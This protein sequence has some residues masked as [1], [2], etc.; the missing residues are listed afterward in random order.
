MLGRGGIALLAALAL[1][2]CVGGVVP[3]TSSGSGPVA[4]PSP[5][6]RPAG[7][8][9]QPVPSTPLAPIPSTAVPDA[10]TAVTAGLA[11]GPSVSSLPITNEG[12]ERALAAFRISCPSLVRRTDP[13]GLTRGADWKPACDA[14]ARG[15]DARAFFA[16]W[17]EAVQVGDGKAFATGYYI[18]E[19]A[20]SRSHRPGYAPIYARP[21]DLVDVDLGQFSADLK[22][23]KIRGRVEGTNFVPYY[24]RTMIEEGAL[25]GKARILGYAVDPVELFFLQVQ[26]SGLVRMSDGDVL[27]IGYDSQ[28]G[29]DY[30][31]IGKLML[32]RGLIGRGEASMQ[33]IVAWLHANPEQGRAIMRENKSYVFFRVLDGPP[34]GAMGLPVSD[35]ATVAADVRFVPLGAPVFL[36]MDRTD[37]TGLW[38]AQDTGGAIKGTNRFDTFWGAGDEAR[39]IAGGMS[40][41]GTAFLLVPTGTL[42]RLGV[43]RP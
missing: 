5:P 27:R 40:A 12:A 32:D 7:P 38:V 3:P 19:I 11:A 26:G 21:S 28:N 34:L 41:R 17:F 33:G 2:A 15:G 29:R 10:V 25:T 22:G 24:D 8:V 1:S 43:A 13:T 14:A 31:G 39:A 23:K 30:T 6:T 42:A 20:G 16:R 35:Q 37:A 9:R 36:S 18:P 4:R